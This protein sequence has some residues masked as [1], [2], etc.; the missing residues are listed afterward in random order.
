MANDETSI[1]FLIVQHKTEI[2]DVIL[3]YQEVLSET[4]S[5][6]FISMIRT[7]IFLP[8]LP[9][10]APEPTNVPPTHADYVDRNSF[11]PYN[12][13]VKAFLHNK[14]RMTDLLDQVKFIMDK[15]LKS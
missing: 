8:L 1:S 12:Q 11:L 4:F 5:D 6:E 7:S 13:D 15:Q 10:D 14:A 2:L 3:D 9:P